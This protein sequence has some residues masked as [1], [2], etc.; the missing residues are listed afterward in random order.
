MKSIVCMMFVTFR[1]STAAIFSPY[2]QV[3]HGLPR[4]QQ[5]DR[6]LGLFG[7]PCL[8]LTEGF[9]AQGFQ[10]LDTKVVKGDVAF[11]LG[12]NLDLV[13]RPN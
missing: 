1:P 10:C 13:L 9:Q 12:A 8:L 7:I 5:V 4:E 3:V 11:L 6:R 2:A